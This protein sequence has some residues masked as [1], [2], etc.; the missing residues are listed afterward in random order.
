MV[1]KKLKAPGNLLLDAWLGGVLAEGI[2]DVL[3]VLLIAD[4]DTRF[5]RFAIRENISYDEAKKEVILRDSS[6]FE[7]V[8]NIYKRTDFFDKKNYSLVIDTSS[9]TVNDIVSLILKRLS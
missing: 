1:K 3:K 5:K 2:E 9:Q 4:N 7:K 6:W 8:K